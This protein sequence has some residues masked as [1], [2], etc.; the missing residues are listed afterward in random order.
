MIQAQGQYLKDEQEAAVLKTQADQERVKVRRSKFDLDQYI[1]ER[2]PTT[3]DNREQAMRTKLRR[4]LNNPPVTEI[5]SAEALNSVL[6]YMK[7]LPDGVL[8]RSRARL[9][10]DALAHIN[11]AGGKGSS[12]A[13]F[14]NGGRLEWTSVLKD[15]AFEK[16]RDRLEDL[17]SETFRAAER[18]RS[19]D[20]GS[21]KAMTKG[22][23]ELEAALKRQA[24]DFAPSE[25]IEAKRYLRALDTGLNTL[26][27]GDVSEASKEARRCRT[28]G[29][30][31]KHMA[32]SGLRFDAALPG[33]EDAYVALHTT[34]VSACERVVP[35]LTTTIQR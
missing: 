21:I 15:A 1:S 20:R 7:V 29:E 31:V 25:Y 10:A 32:T 17:A 18:G 23:D 22:V 28:V 13:I 26:A 34:L 3:E 11:V 24:T 12:L 2:T 4:S 19:I 33:D 35:E 6:D 9:D 16:E 5:H 8:A 30:L 14:K 27:K